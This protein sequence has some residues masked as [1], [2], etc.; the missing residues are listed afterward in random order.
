MRKRPIFLLWLAMSLTLVSCFEEDQPVPP[1][2]PPE[3][4][5]SISFNESLYTHQSYLDF[6]SG[7][8]VGVHAN[9]E[10]V[11]AF[12]C[13]DTGYHIR[14][15]SADLWALAH[16][17]ST[18]FN[19]DFS[20]IEEGAWQNDKS[21]G[22]PDSTAVGSWVSMEDSIP[23]YTREVMLLGLYNGTYAARYKVQFIGLSDTSYLFLAGELDQ[24]IADTVHIQKDPAFN[25][26]HYSLQEGQQRHLEPPR[27]DWD[28]LFTQYFTILYTDDGIPAPYFVR[29]VWQNPWKVQSALDTTTHFLDIHLE[30]A[31]AMEYTQV[32]DAIGY[33][34]K[35]V[36]VDEGSNSAEYRVRQG[37]TY[38]LRDPEGISYKFRFTSYVNSLGE[39][40]YPS[41][42]F[43]N[44]DIE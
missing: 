43:A 15:N 13:A 18:D 33:D 42:E 20:R 14:V 38:L 34:W 1:Y 8:I 7:H 35:S 31:W 36:T 19:G 44:L 3:D 2:V 10:W 5:E 21:D 30:E 12:D 6:S 9:S 29:G 16:T 40:G 41:L 11:L 25:Q 37:Y 22:N 39:K 26:V 24:V 23:V 32:Q 4:V 27:E 17:G 28:L